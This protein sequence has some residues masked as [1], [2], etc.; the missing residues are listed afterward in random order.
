MI[1][2]SE[3]PENRMASERSYKRHSG[4]EE[5]TVNADQE[6]IE[7]RKKRTL[8]GNQ[9]AFQFNI[10]PVSKETRERILDFFSSS[11]QNSNTKVLKFSD[12]ES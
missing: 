4:Q 7:G 8:K 3:C 6:E 5:D 12:T 9:E 10:L 11:S 1:G 2:N